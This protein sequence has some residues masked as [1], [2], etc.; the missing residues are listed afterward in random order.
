M[1][2]MTGFGSGRFQLGTRSYRV[3]ARSVNNRFLD[4]K[5]R[6]PWTDGAIESQA[7]AMIRARVRRGRV[8][9]AAFEE[10]RPGSVALELDETIARGLRDALERLAGILGCE[11]SVAAALVG[12]VPGLLA[13]EAAPPNSEQLWSALAGGLAAALDELEVMR[14]REG[15]STVA[16]LRSH[17]DELVRLREQ[18]ASLVAGEPAR[19]RDRLLERVARLQ[20]ASTVDPVRLAEEVALHADRCDVNEELARLASHFD[21]LASLIDDEAGLEVGRRIEFLLQEIHRELNTV[22]SKSVTAEVAHLAVEAKSAVE[23]MREQAQNVE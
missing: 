11:P 6:L 3:E 23:R 17:L 22:A 12:P 8:E 7:H 15:A 16:D 18:I 2:S 1:I 9:V 20:L 21:Q 4:L 10:R 13:V 14:R 5:L 19:Q